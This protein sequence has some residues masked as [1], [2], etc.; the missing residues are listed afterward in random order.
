MLHEARAGD[1]GGSPRHHH[2][3]DVRHDVGQFVADALCAVHRHLDPRRGAARCAHRDGARRR[4][5]G[6]G[7]GRR[8]AAAGRWRRRSWRRRRRRPTAV[9]VAARSSN[10]RRRHR[11]RRRRR[12]RPTSAG[13]TRRTAPRTFRRRCSSRCSS[14]TGATAAIGRIAFSSRLSRP[15]RPAAAPHATPRA[16]RR[17]DGY[18]RRREIPDGER[19]STAIHLDD[20]VTRLV[21]SSRASGVVKPYEPPIQHRRQRKSPSPPAPALAAAR[22]R[23]SLRRA[24]RRRRRSSRSPTARRCGDEPDGLGAEYECMRVTS[25]ESSARASTS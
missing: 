11:L 18:G 25:E 7:G 8:G 2:R 24:R 14:C 12:R 3:A 9:A 22:R 10:H 23:R 15:P 4:R 17:T 1:D 19:A 20:D 21:D 5:G 16:R 6:G 13:S